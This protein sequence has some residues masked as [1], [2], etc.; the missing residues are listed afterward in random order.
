MTTSRTTTYAA[1]PFM[2]IDGARPTT[3]TPR[4]AK[5]PSLRAPVAARVAPAEQP[6]RHEPPRAEAWQKVDTTVEPDDVPHAVEMRE[7]LKQRVALLQSR[8]P[9]MK[10]A[11]REETLR[12]ILAAQKRTSELAQWVR[13]RNRSTINSA[14]GSGA[15]IRGLLD[16]LDRLQD[17]GAR[18]TG[19]EQDLID[20]AAEYL[21]M[22]E[23]QSAIK[24]ALRNGQVPVPPSDEDVR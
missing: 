24:K 3:L 5:P 6:K 18:L 9:T 8:V 19:E 11:Q 17:D 20:E 16:A 7:A 22:T 1:A 23:E 4:A 21:S 10:G 13:D 2:G 15:I 12:L 14:K